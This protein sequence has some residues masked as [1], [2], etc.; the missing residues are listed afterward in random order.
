[1]TSTREKGQG[2]Q[3]R[4]RKP[5]AD[6][7]HILPLQD[8]PFFPAQTAPVV[9]NESA[10]GDTLEALSGQDPVPVGLVLVRHDRPDDATTEDFYDTGT[11]VLMHHPVLSNGKIQFIAE[12][13][14]RFRI[15]RWHKES[16]PLVADIEFVDD[17]LRQGDKI[18]AYAIEIVQC[19]TQLA[20]LNPLYADEL[21]YL[22]ENY[23]LNRPSELADLAAT[24]TTADRDDLQYVLSTRDLTLR[25]ERVLRLIRKELQVAQIQAR[26][27]QQVEKAVS[28]NQRRFFLKE[29]LK[30]IQR[31]LGIA[32]DDRTADIDLFVE[33]LQ[34]KQ[35]PEDVQRRVSNELDRLRVLEAGSPEYAVTRTYLDVL[36][37][38][39]WG[40]AT[41]DALDLTAARKTLEATHAGLE[42]VKTRILE[43]LALAAYSGSVKGSILLLVGPPGV[44]KTSIGKTI[45]DALGRKFQR[46]SLGGMRDEAEIKGHRRTYV[47]AMP[48][49]I[50]QA[51]RRA[52]TENPVIMLDEIDKIGASFQGDPASALLEVLD[53]EQNQHFLDNYLDVPIDLGK[54][55]FVCTANQVDTIP[56]PLL[57][58]ME[59]IR[60]SGYL[61]EEK[62]D[63]AS[64]YLLPK[65]LRRAG[66]KPSA[67]RI[68]RKALRTLI[69]GYAREAGVRSLDK[70]LA[71]LVRR[72]VIRLLDGSLSEPV[73]IGPEELRDWLGPPHFIPTVP[74]RAVGV[75]TGLAWTPMGGT[76][77]DIESALVE[78]GRPELKLTGNL[79]DV[80][81]E[82]AEI[83]LSFVR[84]RGKAYGFGDRLARSA[85]HVHVPEG[86]TP[87]DGPS[88][89]ITLACSLISAALEKRIRKP[90]AMSGELTLTG[91]VISVGGIQEK[92]IAARRAGIR[93]VIL[94]SG[95]IDQF[96]Q[97]PPHL[98]EK[99]TFH[100]VRHFDEVFQLAF[101]DA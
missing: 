18:R 77:L 83:A 20:P 1:M 17:Q 85:I 21:Q 95:V 8:R 53:P 98:K 66:L 12:G 5:K 84:S 22:L 72:A 3:T 16:R 97:L 59:V 4:I 68:S 65:Q 36:T 62:I 27:H 94:P 44:G 82:S 39:P 7:L 50:V 88:A 73:R 100:F 6:R 58:R 70:H 96:E 28:D 57:D 86:A 101:G 49:R 79:G 40:I 63:I 38:L 48:G 78:G 32:K 35:P 26:I 93:E 43:F 14:R 45:A 41:S 99:L 52:G 56:P 74:H 9:M 81:R 54:I 46:V 92:I 55:L 71:R 11:M 2:K 34:I 25:M 60:L 91:Q 90:I 24:V 75:V 31:E 23:D 67:V 64:R 87:K 80:M 15:L 61:T 33:R 69:E 89:G 19:L 37:D 30:A 51:L 29:Q 47:A 13:Q 42:D 10:W 76:T